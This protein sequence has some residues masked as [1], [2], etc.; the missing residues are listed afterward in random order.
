MWNWKKEARLQRLAAESLG[1][2]VS[3][4]TQGELNALSKARDKA[5]AQELSTAITLA[6]LRT[7]HRKELRKLISRLAG[8]DPHIMQAL[9]TARE[10][11][12]FRWAAGEEAASLPGWDV[13]REARFSALID[14][15]TTGRMTPAEA[16]ELRALKA[17]RDKAGAE[18][19]DLLALSRAAER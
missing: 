10:Q 11:A 7:L 19:A 8:Y 6:W 16:Q 12:D 4:R 14:T 5:T 2:R 9:T 17:A 18:G 15:S 3:Q 13:T 1:R